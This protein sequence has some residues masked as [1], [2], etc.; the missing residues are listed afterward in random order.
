MTES[1]TASATT[2]YRL[3]V[4]REWQK[5]PVQRGTEQ[6]LKGLLDRAFAHHGR[7]QVAQYRREVEAR[8][9][10]LISQARQNA[11]VDLYLPL[12][13]RERN[14]PA[15][16]LISYAEFGAL[17]APDPQRVLAQVLSTTANA[18]QVELD[19]TPA[20]RTE[21]TYEADASRG[22]DSPSRRVEYLLPVPGT[23]DSWL[24]SSFSTFGAGDPEDGT[25]GLLCALFD[26]IMGT[27]RWE[28]QQEHA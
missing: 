20:M 9:K 28:H 7:D 1:P 18:E 23:P 16:F 14:L 6:A 4:P 10:K 8:L 3:V 17:D 22:V 24:V 12:G 25:A 21:R 26:A 27:F 19:G 11:G 5:I 2:G 15:S 13:H